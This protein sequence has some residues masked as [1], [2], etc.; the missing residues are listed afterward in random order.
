MRQRRT[1]PFRRF[2]E[3][4]RIVVML[5][6]ARCDREDVWIKNNIFGRKAHNIDQQTVSARTDFFAAFK[7]IGLTFFIK[8]HD[9]RCRAVATT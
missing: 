9:H 7:R 5:I 2:D 8:S 6:N 3:I 1:N 4:H